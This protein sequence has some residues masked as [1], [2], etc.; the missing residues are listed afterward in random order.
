MPFFKILLIT[1]FTIV[2][3]YSLVRPFASW[4]ARVFFVSGSILGLLSVADSSYSIMISDFLG[5]R[6]A[7]LYLYMTLLTVFLFVGYTLNRFDQLNKKISILVKEI[8]IID[9]TNIKH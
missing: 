4:I 6:E 5:M 1:F 7:D 9:K 2:L 8:A 3:L